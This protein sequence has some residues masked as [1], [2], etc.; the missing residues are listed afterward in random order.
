MRRVARWRM[1]LAGI[2]ATL[3]VLSC[4]YL[5]AADTRKPV[6][7]TVTI[8]GASFTPEVLTVKAGDTIVW[9]NKDI[10]PHTATS[11]AAGFDSLLIATGKSWTYEAATTGDFP[12]VCTFHPTMKGT[13]RVR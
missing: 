5:G 2:A 11:K 4:G 3:A 7:H 13:L 6:T 8:D 10:I 12:Y 1:S 9:M